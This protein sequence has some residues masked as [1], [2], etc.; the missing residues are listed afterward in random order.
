MTGMQ[1]A[2]LQNDWSDMIPWW[3][4]TAPKHQ[5]KTTQK[6]WQL[7]HSPIAKFTPALCWLKI[8][9]MWTAQWT[10][11][12][13]AS[14]NYTYLVILSILERQTLPSTCQHAMLW[15]VFRV[16]PHQSWGMKAEVLKLPKPTLIPPLLYECPQ[17]LYEANA[18]S[19]CGN[20]V[21]RHLPQVF[22]PWTNY[23]LIW[24]CLTEH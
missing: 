2:F 15:V 24:I 11:A 14:K 21:C 22:W 3:F 8:A 16:D 1:T 9:P 13:G 6:K 20:R 18:L 10:P 23:H 17:Q 7:S 12:F 5:I 4:E 19:F